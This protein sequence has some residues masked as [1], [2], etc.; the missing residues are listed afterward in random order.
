MYGYLSDVDCDGGGCSV[1][2][3]GGG[4]YV[5]SDGGRGSTSSV[6]IIL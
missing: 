2:N 6:T 1:D 3:D 5:D 4:D